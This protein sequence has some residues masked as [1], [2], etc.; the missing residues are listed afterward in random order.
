MRVFVAILFACF[1]FSS[2]YSQIVTLSESNVPIRKLL[3]EIRK[4]TG[5]YFSLGDL[6]IYSKFTVD[7][8][9]VPLE[10]A[11]DEIF[12]DKPYNAIIINK[13]IVVVERKR[14]KPSRSFFTISG[15]VISENGE[16]LKDATISLLNSKKGII[17]NANGEFTLTEIKER[18]TIVV[19]SIGFETRTF[20]VNKDTAINCILKVAAKGLDEAVIVAYG[21]TT[22][23]LNTGNVFKVRAKEIVN[24]PVS[25]FIAALPGRVPGM[26]ISQT[27]GLPGTCYKT[28]IRGRASIGA[29]RGII[30]ETNTLVI[31]DGVPFSPNNNNI[32]TIASGSALSQGRNSFDLINV[33]DIESIEVLKDADATAIYGS[34]GANGVILVTTKKG[35]IGKTQFN[36]NANTGSGTITRYPTML[37]TKQYVQMRKQAILN[38]GAIPNISNAPDL[39][40]WDTTRYTDFRKLLIG[41]TAKIFN[42]HIGIGGGN[43]Q[44]QYLASGSYRR[45]TTVFPGDF[46][47]NI[48]S[49]NT[50]LNYKSG[51]NKFKAAVGWIT[52]HDNNNSLAR[53]LTGFVNQPPNAPALYDSAGNLTWHHNGYSFNNPMATLQQPYYSKTNNYLLSFNA[54]YYLIDKLNFKINGGLNSIDTKEFLLQP[55]SSINSFVNPNP[56]G[57]SYFAKCNIKSWIIEP[58]LEYNNAIKNG[59]FIF[60]LGSTLQSVITIINNISATGFVSDSLTDLSKADSVTNTPTNIK[61]KYVGL[62][63]RLS[64]NLLDRYLINITGRRDGSS[65]FGSNKQFGNFGAIGI[66][67]IFSSEPNFTTELPFISF[68]KLRGSYGITGSDQVGDYEFLD[69]WIPTQGTYQGIAG[70]EPIQPANP[71]YS[72]ETNKKVEVAIDLGLFN[73]KLFVSSTFYR[74]RSGNQIISIPLPSTTGFERLQ[75]A[76]YPAVVQNTGFEFIIQ[77]G[78]RVSKLFELNSKAVITFPKNKLLKFPDLS[79]SLYTGSYLNVGGS[80]SSIIGLKYLGVDN[81]SGLFKFLDIDGNGAISYPNDYSII[82]NK[83]PKYYGSLLNNIKFKNWDFEFLVEFRRQWNNNMLYRIY[84]TRPPGFTKSNIPVLLNNTWQKQGDQPSLQKL[85]ASTNSSAYNEISNFLASSGVFSNASY[86]KLKYISLSYSLPSSLL[87]KLH[88]KNCKFYV[89]GNNLAIFTPFKGTDPET[90][91]T[92]TLSPLRTMNVGIHITY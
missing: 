19:S 81:N 72:W 16:L 14:V 50:Q 30:P 80:I 2:G 85:T 37:N 77:Y 40:R 56:K 18:S 58:H 65:R 84:D 1:A 29:G 12:K 82:G 42:F 38:D 55:K 35:F 3:V 23:R 46:S 34:R 54:D 32:P 47:D 13:I 73:N 78:H 66:G 7:V 61:Y 51:N 89:A 6:K 17:T 90:I 74:H 31:I 33:K 9:N 48:F 8:R 70:L 57:T 59:K 24:Q 64:Y 26:L 52:S 5:Y 71:N 22:N 86:V 92:F 39:Y 4:Q 53:D 44:F 63:G 87:K 43:Q 76:N 21:R 69:R 49:T 79:K 28:E 60:Q 91:D 10:K 68:G 83:D 20:Q 67:W 36:I 45:E 62:F 25:N 15:I 41:G 11:L 27:N 75:A 88:L